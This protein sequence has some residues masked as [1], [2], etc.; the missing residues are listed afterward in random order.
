MEFSQKDIDSFD[1]Y[2]HHEMSAEGKAGFEQQLNN[3]PV[4]QK[5]FTDYQLIVQVVQEAPETGKW[6]DAVGTV[7]RKMLEEETQ[8]VAAAKPRR[9][10]PVRMKIIFGLLILSLIGVGVWCFLKPGPQ[11]SQQQ[12]PENKSMPVPPPVAQTDED[13]EPLLGGGVGERFQAAILRVNGQRNVIHPLDTMNVTLKIGEAQKVMLKG[14]HL[15]LYFPEG[16]MPDPKNIQFVELTLD[17]KKV[18]YLKMEGKFYPILEGKQELIEETD[19]NVLRL[20]KL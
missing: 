11:K 3:D 5:A 9:T 20:L 16:K 1:A 7:R 6:K 18:L 14:D 2:L 17:V 19:V 15:E 12:T 13:G 10:I 4:F 8:E